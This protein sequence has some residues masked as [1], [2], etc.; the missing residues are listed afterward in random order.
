MLCILQESLVNKVLQSIL[1]NS[2]TATCKPTVAETSS[3]Q[4]PGPVDKVMNWD[5][6]LDRRPRVDSLDYKSSEGYPRDRHNR[7]S[8]K[9]SRSFSPERL[10]FMK[11]ERSMSRSHSRRSPR[12][13]QLHTPPRPRGRSPSY[14]RHYPRHDEYDRSRQSR[15]LSPLTRKYFS[16]RPRHYRP[17]LS[18]TRHQ[19]RGHE[20]YRS[21]SPRRHSRSPRRRYHDARSP[22]SRKIVF[23]PHRH[24]HEEGKMRHESP[25]KAR[26]ESRSPSRTRIRERIG[27]RRQDPLVE[28]FNMDDKIGV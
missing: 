10:R 14:P 27:V 12:R 9:R 23:S 4:T 13:S 26:K 3:L 20:R 28:V 16:P 22:R 24:A 6:N 17:S 15:V 2:A 7:E 19:S 21:R 25:A 5:T 8:R 18:P 11:R 1:G